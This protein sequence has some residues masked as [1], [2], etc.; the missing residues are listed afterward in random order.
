MKLEDP[1]L[2]TAF[3]NAQ[4]LMQ[5]SHVS[6]AP[7]EALLGYWIANRRPIVEA[8]EWSG[9][10]LDI[11]CANGFLLI[12]LQGWSEHKLIPYGIDADPASIE[13]ARDLLPEYANQFAQVALEN[14]IEPSEHSLPES[15][16]YVFWCVWDGLDF[17]EPQCQTYAKNTFGAARAGG[18][19]ILGFFDTNRALVERQLEWL[20]ERYGACTRIIR[21]DVVFAWWDCAVRAD[22]SD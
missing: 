13:A 2:L 9:T 17:N 18:R 20:V 21:L 6:G 15:F 10:F 4:A 22:R 5:G 7:V 8:I 11:G 14:F 3:P 16:D 12:C 19:V 1:E